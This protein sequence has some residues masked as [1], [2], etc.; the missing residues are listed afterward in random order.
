MTTN[1]AAGSQQWW[2]RTP[3]N[4]MLWLYGVLLTGLAVRVLIWLQTGSTPLHIVDENHYARLAQNLLAGNGFAIGPG[5]PT[6]MRPPLYP[7]LIA[8]IWW[9][10]GSESLQAV[11]LFQIVLSLVNVVLIYSLGR[12]AFSGRAGLLAAALFCFYPSYVGFASLLYS[13]VVFLFLISLAALTYLLMIR[14]V[15]V[16]FAMLT[17]VILG[18]AALTRSVAWPFLLVLMP[19]LFFSIRVGIPRRLMF[20]FVVFLG[21]ALVVGPWSYRNTKLQGT[22]ALVDT[23][24]GFNLMMGNY[25]H[26]PR[27]RA[28]DAVALRGELSWAH[29]LRQTEPDVRSWTDGQKEQWAREQAKEFMLANPGLTI[30]RFLIKFANF[31]GMERTIIAGWQRGYY[32]PPMWLVVLGTVA[33]V[34]G[35][36][37]VVTLGAAGL[38]LSRPV[39]LNFERFAFVFAMVTCGLHS[40]VFGHPRYHLPLIPFLALYSAALIQHMDWRRLGERR[41]AL[42]AAV[43]SILLLSFIWAREILF[44]E[45]ARLTLFLERFGL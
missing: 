17:G 26:T 5:Q 32:I 16:L 19:V 11:R 7:S 43:L 35:Y 10:V 4:S 39:D 25:E 45:G 23:M 30:E 40:L 41:A 20:V 44:V 15:S 37:A 34:F 3:S 13:E 28:W 42:V 36:V 2:R 29:R 12:M 31:W 14:K 27:N 6:S 9:L 33:I 38:F 22:F 21:F 8:S 24:G 18:A 1:E